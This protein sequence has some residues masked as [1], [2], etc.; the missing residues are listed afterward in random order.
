MKSAL[1]T[2]ANKSIG[3]EIARQ[4]ARKGYFIYLGS[5][6]MEKGIKAADQLKKEGLPMIEAVQIDVCDKV[7]I[8]AAKNVIIS[9]S[10]ALD[11]LINNAGIAG[12]LPQL[13]SVTDTDEIRKVFD[14]NFFGTIDVTQAFLSLLIGADNPVIVNVTSGLSSLTLQ[15]D[16]EWAYYPYKGASYGPSKTAQNAYTVALAYEL[17]D[18]GFKI[19][20]VDPGFTATDFNQHRGHGTVQEA[21]SF[22]IKYAAIG[23][24]GPTGKFFSIESKTDNYEMPW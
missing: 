22:I 1:I 14:T 23:A 7:S 15:S 11:L 21:A 4:L 9:K 16:P 3:F 13:A 8:E 12:G 18:K 5:R 19:N 2:G 17:K 20:A 24:D 6:N 10:P